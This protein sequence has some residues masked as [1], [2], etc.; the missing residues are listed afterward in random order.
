MNLPGIANLLP[1]AHHVLMS[2]GI[3]W[4]DQRT[5]LAVLESGSLSGAARRLALAQPTVRRRI[6]TLE[7][8]LGLALFTR[9]PNGLVPTE[10]AVTLGSYART[11]ASASEAFVRAAAAPRDGIGGT[12]RVSVSEFVGIE[13]LPAM[14][15]PLRERFP[16]LAIEMTLSNL[17]A[18]LLDQEADIAVRMHPPRQD[19]LL[20][21]HVGAV[22]LHFFAHR[23]YVGRNGLPQTVEDFADHALIGPDRAPSDLAIAEALLPSLP[24]PRFAIRTDSHAAQAAAIRAGLGIGVLQAPIGYADTDLVA[25]LPDRLVHA[26]DTWIVTHIDLRRT[27]RIAVVFEHLVEAFGT[28]VTRI[29]S[30]D[31]IE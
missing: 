17:P 18:D 6:E 11:M 19:A 13:V 22:P 21:Q 1:M 2:R 15:A 7:A 29:D 8:Q 5:F 3:E 30:T 10:Q 31:R 9:S 12:V 16:A 24:H 27:P 14:L 26:I 20:A 25:V 28:Y 23:D 4:E